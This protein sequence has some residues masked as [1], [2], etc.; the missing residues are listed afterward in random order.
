[1]SPDPAQLPSGD[2][3]D[4][5]SLT[6]IMGPEGADLDQT[7]YADPVEQAILVDRTRPRR[8]RS[9]GS[10]VPASAGEQDEPAPPDVRIGSYRLLAPIA[11]GGMGILYRGEHVL[12]GNPVAI[13]CMQPALIGDEDTE[14]R[15]FSEAIATSRIDHPGVP[16]VIDYGRDPGHG[17]FI[18]LELLEGQTLEQIQ[19]AGTQLSLGQMLALA[20]DVAAIVGVAHRHGILHRDI[21]P[22][23]IH[24][25]E[26]PRLPS[27]YR[28]RVLDFGV[29]KFLSDRPTD[30]AQTRHDHLVGTAWYMS[31]EQTFGPADVDARSD[32]Y[33]LG[34]VLF[35]MVVGRLP[36]QGE[37]EAVVQARR[38][39]EPPNPCV[40]R[41]SL[42]AVVGE[43]VLR[44][45]ARDP[46]VRPPSM[47]AVHDELARVEAE[48]SMALAAPVASFEVATG[49]SPV[50]RVRRLA[51]QHSRWLVAGSATAAALGL[52][53]ALV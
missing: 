45:I 41:P 26:D 11:Q 7:Q 52:L 30:A 10:V 21:K 13:K 50:Y 47:D 43:L 27:G 12:L 48:L 38:Y 5:A 44:M 9:G 18:V 32:V 37:F 20:K 8:P 22:D 14:R 28:V 33:S 15:F 34:C 3:S 17:P 29:A 19:R 42:P 53:L 39:L 31:P 51:S 1:M 36:F 35:A 2:T 4:Y 40:M 23:N 16:K 25:A 6:E 49:P 46:A 24:L